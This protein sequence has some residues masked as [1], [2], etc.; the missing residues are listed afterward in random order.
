MIAGL[1]KGS[2]DGYSIGEPWATRAAIDDIGYEIA[3][4]LEIWN[5]HPG[6]VLGVREEWALAY[7]NTHI[8][9]VKALLE[10]C[11]FCANPDHQDEVREILAR[12]EYLAM[13]RDYIYMAEIDLSV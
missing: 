13:D 5:G 10:A 7:P 8:A 4:D 12:S 6:K 1:Q 9:L 3:T 2:I 11:Q